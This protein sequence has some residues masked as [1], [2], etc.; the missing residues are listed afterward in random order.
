MMDI[1]IPYD[2]TGLSQLFTPDGFSGSFLGGGVTENSRVDSAIKYR[3]KVADFTV[4][5]LYKVSGT[6]GPDATAATACNEITLE[7]NHGPF[8]IYAGYQ[9]LRNGVTYAVNANGSI[10]T[11]TTPTGTATVA[12][13]GTVKATVYNTTD[14]QFGV[15]Y[16]VGPVLVC[17]G[18]QQLKFQDPTPGDAAYFSSLAP[19]SQYAYGQQIASYTVNAIGTAAGDPDK[20]QTMLHATAAWDVTS[21]FKLMGGYYHV[22]INDYSL[23]LPASAKG[24]QTNA[25]V[26]LIA[27]YAITKAFDVYIGE[28]NASASGNAINAAT[29][30]YPGGDDTT[31]NN[32]FGMGI[33][34]KF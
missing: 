17:V 5:A 26:T 25:Y 21:K 27:D 2:A 12:S 33:R 10:V 8:G 29:G 28:M 4:S 16:Q 30:W 18:Y 9:D 7:Y 24:S 1:M 34:Y 20:K 32:V 23:N 11:V 6:K 15:K 22:G 13:Q 19:G 14:L 31:K 3:V